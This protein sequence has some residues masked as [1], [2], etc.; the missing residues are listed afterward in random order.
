M[1]SHYVGSEL[2]LF[3]EARHWKA[4]VAAQ[5]APFIAGSVL[6]V[7]AGVGSNIPFLQNQSVTHWTALEPD[8]AQADQIRA[9]SLE[10]LP[11][12]RVIS[13]TLQAIDA[14]ERFT[15]ILYIDVLEHIEDDVSELAR[16]SAH[17]DA[18]GYLIVLVPAHQFLFSAFD[19]AIGHYRRYNLPSLIR[20]TPPG[21]VVRRSIMLDAAGF[22]A[23]LANR[24]LLRK[25]MPEA[26]QIAF[27]DNVLVPISRLLDPVTLHRFGKTAITVWSRA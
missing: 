3:A 21:C 26:G 9:L 11:P 17:L 25:A 18:G 15:T 24:L 7:G 12:P 10:I 19:A 23:S 27:W 13:G 22:F 1:N 20:L 6:E 14:S 8:P 2:A 5:L 4:Y 16:A